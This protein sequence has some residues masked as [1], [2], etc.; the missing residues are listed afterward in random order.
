[1]A[2][3]LFKGVHWGTD[4]EP[5]ENLNLPKN[6]VMEVDDK[7]GIDPNDF[8]IANILSDEFGFCVDGID[9]VKWWDEDGFINL[10]I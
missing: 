9:E 10:L 6:F 2:Q 4:G 7:T 1:M 8:D 5:I 3:L